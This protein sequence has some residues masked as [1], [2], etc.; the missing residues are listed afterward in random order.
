MKKLKL[1]RLVFGLVGLCTG[2]AQAA[3]ITTYTG[4]PQPILNSANDAFYYTTVNINYGTSTSIR[5]TCQT[6]GC[7]TNNQYQNLFGNTEQSEVSAPP[8]YTVIFSTDNSPGSANDVFF[9]NTGSV[10]LSG[11][12]LVL[13]EDTNGSRSATQFEL[14]ANGTLISNV[15]ILSAGSTYSATYGNHEIQVSDSFAPVTATS[16]EAVFVNNSDS[17]FTGVRA[18]DLQGLAAA[19]ASP[20]PEPTPLA[21]TAPFLLAAMVVRKRLAA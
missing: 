21:L 20:A 10:T 17:S 16:W 1:Y 15:S 7:T 14:F 11:Y 2:L 5:N 3:S 12:N 13:A 9:A 18:V 19:A 6:A 4:F 8:A